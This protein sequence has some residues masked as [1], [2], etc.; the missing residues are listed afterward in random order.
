MALLGRSPRVALGREYPYE[1]RCLSFFVQSALALERH[2]E[3]NSLSQEQ[4]CDFNDRSLGRS[5]QEAMASLGF[6]LSGVRAMA[7]PSIEFPALQDRI[8]SFPCSAHCNLSAEDPSGVRVK[9]VGLDCWFALP[10]EPFDAQ[11]VQGI[12]VSLLCQTGADCS[13][14]WRARGERFS[15]DRSIRVR[16]RPDLHWQVLRFRVCTHALWRSKVTELRLD[17]GNGVSGSIRTDVCVR[18]VR[19]IA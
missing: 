17:L 4:L 1:D 6:E 15:E 5:L 7:L 12:W 16:V 13:L 19:F 3:A 9:A 11:S 10:L 18:W 2:I 8:A 14:L